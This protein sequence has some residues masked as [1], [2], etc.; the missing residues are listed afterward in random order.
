MSEEQWELD[1][2]NQRIVFS[3]EGNLELEE[4]DVLVDEFAEELK[5]VYTYQYNRDRRISLSRSLKNKI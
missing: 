5:Q 2:Q 4:L 3:W 1:I